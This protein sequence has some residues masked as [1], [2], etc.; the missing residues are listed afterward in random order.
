MSKKLTYVTSNANKFAE[1]SAILPGL[2]RL[3]LD[4]P[5]IQS[6]DLREIISAKLDA[7]VAAVPDAAERVLIVEDG[8]NF[9]EGCGN[10]PGP[11]IK[12]FIE[13]LG[14]APGLY[15]FAQAFGAKRGKIVLGVG[16]ADGERREFFEGVIEG[17]IVAPRGESRFGFDPIFQPDGFTKTFA[18]M[19][20]AE[21]NAISHR[22]LAL[23]KVK[24]FL[25]RG[26]SI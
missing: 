22:S 8:A 3:A 18:E 7:A 15:K 1:A 20:S 10:L 5:E 17:A 9:F 16:L 2:E 12:F 26:M 11:F 13:E 19:T 24:T 21:K 14:G 4:L 6:T 25:E 23:A